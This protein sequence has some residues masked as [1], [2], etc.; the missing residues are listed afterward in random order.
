VDAWLSKNPVCQVQD[1]SRLE[2]FVA[3]QRSGAPLIA[4]ESVDVVVSNCVLNLVRDSEKCKVFA[5]IYRVLRSGGRA[6][7]SDVVSDEPVPVHLKND[8]ELWTG[9]ISG[10]L[11]EG[12][13]LR[14]FEEAG[15][16]VACPP[17]TPAVL[18]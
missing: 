3:R 18:R 12:E 11:Q 13:F 10:A 16:Y 7:I 5:E 6:V 2:D 17:K 8:P 9:W 4:N 15:F 14:E 1:L